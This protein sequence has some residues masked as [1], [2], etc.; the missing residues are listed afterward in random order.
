MD[1]DWKNSFGILMHPLRARSG[2]VALK[3]PK[4]ILHKHGHDAYQIKGN[5]E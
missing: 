1:E 5:E 2:S 4:S 3:G